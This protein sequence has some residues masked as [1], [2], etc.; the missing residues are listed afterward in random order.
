MHPD[1]EIKK[2]CLNSLLCINEQIERKKKADE[3]WKVA[4]INEKV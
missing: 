3:P 1:F 2:N 4:L